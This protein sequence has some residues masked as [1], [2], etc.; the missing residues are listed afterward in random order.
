[1][2][3]IYYVKGIEFYDSGFSKAHHSKHLPATVGVLPRNHGHAFTY[4][5]LVYLMRFD[6]NSPDD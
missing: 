6:Q 5:S 1:M 4:L 2:H 3:H